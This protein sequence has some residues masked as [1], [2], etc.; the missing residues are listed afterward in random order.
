MVKQVNLTASEFWWTSILTVLATI[1]KDL[2]IT[3]EYGSME[4]QNCKN[5]LNLM[6]SIY[7]HLVAD[8]DVSKVDAIC[9]LESTSIV[10]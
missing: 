2:N 3:T 10:L 7:D 1:A 5:P 8:F 4:I 6:R 9:Y